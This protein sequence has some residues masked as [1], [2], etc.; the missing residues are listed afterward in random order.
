MSTSMQ[1]MPISSKIVCGY[2]PKQ[3]DM[4]MRTNCAVTTALIVLM[5]VSQSMGQSSMPPDRLAKRVYPKTSDIVQ[6]TP[7]PIETPPPFTPSMT[8]S[9]L[10]DKAMPSARNGGFWIGRDSATPGTSVNASAPSRSSDNT[11][12]LKSIFDELLNAETRKDKAAIAKAGQQFV[13]PSPETWFASM[14]GYAPCAGLTKEYQ[15]VQKMLETEFPKL[16]KTLWEHGQTQVSVIAVR[17]PS[18]A[19]ATPAQKRALEGMRQPVALYTVRFWKPGDKQAFNVYSFVYV[20]GTF[21]FAG[22]MQA[23]SAGNTSETSATVRKSTPRPVKG[24]VAGNKQQQVKPQPEVVAGMTP[25]TMRWVP[26]NGLPPRATPQAQATPD[27][28][29]RS[30]PTSVHNPSMLSPSRD[31]NPAA[32]ETPLPVGLP[33]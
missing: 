19:G 31:A 29:A 6:S 10:M 7:G 9:T 17:S 20:D 26:N 14:Y 25:E 8:S 28:F 12:A 2:G 5:G 18:D 13:L 4:S 11:F 33:R 16:I 27:V 23:L 30:T 24:E 21:R 1:P 3:H 32:Y 15:T 22:K